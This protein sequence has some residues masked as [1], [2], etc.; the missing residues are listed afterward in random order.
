MAIGDVIKERRKKLDMTQKQLAEMIRVTP[1]AISKWE[2][3]SGCPD[4]SYIAPLANAL[5]ISTDVLLEHHNSLESYNIRWV[6]LFHRCRFGEPSWEELVDLDNEILQDYPYDVTALYRRVHDELYAARSKEN[7]EEKKKWIWQAEVHCSQLI[8]KH[9]DFEGAIHKMV[10]IK[11]LK[12]EK[13]SA[14][15]WAN[16]CKSRD[17]AMKII[18]HGDELRLHK[19]KLINKKLF[20]LLREMTYPDLGSL[21]AAED[22]IRAVFFDENYLCYYDNL[23]MIEYNRALYYDKRQDIDNTILHLYKALDIAKENMI[24]GREKGIFTVPVF[25]MLSIED[26]P[27]TLIIQ[28]YD[29]LS[30]QP[31]NF[32]FAYNTEQYRRLLEDIK[33]ECRK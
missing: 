1:Q 8:D 31:P 13:E 18:L 14:I 23:M 25:D 32:E 19:Q 4:I 26:E 12:G 3:G 29:I 5:R 17:D 24:R 6:K 9:P 7:D 11:M 22:I 28:L 10:E 2:K 20:E 27:V 15:F 21:R 30:V 33:S 16:K